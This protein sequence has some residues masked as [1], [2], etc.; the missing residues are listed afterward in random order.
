MVN[1]VT[2]THESSYHSFTK[3]GIEQD[4]TCLSRT[5]QARSHELF[6]QPWN[7]Q[8]RTGQPCP[9]QDRTV[10]WHKTMIPT[11]VAKVC[12]V[13]VERRPGIKMCVTKFSAVDL[14]YCNVVSK[15]THTFH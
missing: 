7:P 8:D 4:K 9:R 13:T 11:M 15:D 14:S 6:R 3:A 2:I 10:F 12:H 5:G 1:P